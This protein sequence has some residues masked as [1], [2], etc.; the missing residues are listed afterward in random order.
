MAQFFS[1]IHNLKFPKMSNGVPHKV[2]Q[3]G[4]FLSCYSALF[5]IY[6]I[7]E[8]FVQLVVITFVILEVDVH[9]FLLD[10][11]IHNTNVSF[12]ECY[13]NRCRLKQQKT[14]FQIGRE[15][16]GGV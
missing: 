2:F 3:F 16:L 4:K 11:E 13:T 14:V 1:L 6:P 9:I 8:Y 10:E 12:Q 7:P 5:S 15:Y